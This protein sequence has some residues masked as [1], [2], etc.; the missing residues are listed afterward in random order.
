VPKLG[1]GTGCTAPDQCGTGFCV[2][3]V[4][5]GTACTSTCTACSGALTGGADGTC[6]DVAAN[7]DPKN[8]CGGGGKVCCGQSCSNVQFDNKNCG[9]CG[10]TVPSGGQCLFGNIIPAN[11][12][13]I[14]LLDEGSGTT[15][16]DISGFTDPGTVNLA[17]WMAASACHNGPCLSFDGTVG[18]NNSVTIPYQSELK[19]G[20]SDFTVS[21]WVNATAS[22]AESIAL[23]PTQCSVDEAWELALINGAPS[24]AT[25]GGGAGYLT[26]ASTITDGTWHHVV[27]RRTGTLVELI[28]DGVVQANGSVAA[29][30]SSDGAGT[31]L[32][33]G[34][35]NGCTG[36]EFGGLI[37]SVEMFSRSLTDAEVADI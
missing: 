9:T 10:I 15:T 37:D 7:T 34:N 14:W 31:T 12:A 19:F 28:V 18:S 32:S 5:C 25:F 27:G 16:A 1:Q 6:A 2:D 21:V 35:A 4:C 11:P 20:T 13:G 26:S 29:T 23:T 17:T 36:H 8:Q 30:Y 3:G 24:F 22:G 33:I